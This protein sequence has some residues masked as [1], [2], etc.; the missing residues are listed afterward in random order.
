[1]PMK[2]PL[3][4]QRGYFLFLKTIFIHLCGSLLPENMSIAILF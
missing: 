3:V 1:M 4:N 2:A